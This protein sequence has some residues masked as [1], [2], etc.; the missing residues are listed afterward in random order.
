MRA[1]TSQSD[2]NKYAYK[3]EGFDKDW[4]YIGNKKSATYTNLD[5]NE[6]VFKVKASN[7]DGLWNEKGQSI[8]ITI[9]PPFWKTWWA[10]L[11]YL[12]ILIAAFYLI[13]KY[14]LLRI[15]EKNELK[16][17]RLEKEKIEEINSLKLKLFTNISHDF[18]TPL[19]LIVGPLERMLKNK[20]GSNYIQKQHQTMYRNATVLLQLINQLL[21]F[22][23]NES[24]K[25]KLKASQNNIVLFTENIK[26]SFEDLAEFREIDYSFKTTDINLEIWF[27]VINLKKVLF[28]LL[29]NAFKF[30]PNNGKI[31]IIIST[32]TKNSKK[33]NFV[34]IEIKDNGKGIPKKN[35]NFIFDR[36]Y[37]IERDES[38]RSGTGIGLAL[39]KSIIE[40]HSGSIK[41]KSKEKEGTSFVIL[42]PFGKNHLTKEQIIKE[43][44]EI[45]TVNFYENVIVNSFREKSENKIFEN[46]VIIPEIPTILIVEDNPEA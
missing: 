12:F 2:K 32:T 31:K 30:T 26:K 15:H 13:R 7:N 35:L 46:S 1:A 33:D 45:E 43:T 40:L 39:A 25:L 23:K 5:P 24:G 16:Q 9:L 6:Y 28:N 44:N 22:R 8:K 36:F 10:Y 37:Q 42:L 21:D 20:E 38:S 18:R 19:T 29:S 14:S 41:A 34:K 17:E 4:N 11:L 27:D 3:L